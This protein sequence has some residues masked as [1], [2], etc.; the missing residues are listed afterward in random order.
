V[1]FWKCEEKLDR[2]LCNRYRDLR[3]LVGHFNMLHRLMTSL[4]LEYHRESD[5]DAT[6]SWYHGRYDTREWENPEFGFSHL[7]YVDELDP[8]AT[9]ESIEDPVKSS[10]EVSVVEKELQPGRD[11]YA[12]SPPCSAVNT[13]ISVRPTFLG[14]HKGRVTTLN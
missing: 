7:D 12:S 10:R 13:Q 2:V 5:L 3:V 14:R 11:H 6:S 8:I 4:A 1:L 9:S